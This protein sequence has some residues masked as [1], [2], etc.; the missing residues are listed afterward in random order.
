MKLKAPLL[1]RYGIDQRTDMRRIAMV[2]FFMAFFLSRIMNRVRP[3]NSHATLAD[4]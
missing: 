4:E 2:F 3:T 1:E